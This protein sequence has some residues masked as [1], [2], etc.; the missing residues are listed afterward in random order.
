VRLSSAARQAQE[1]CPPP[2]RLSALLAAR[3]PGGDWQRSTEEALRKREAV[4][5][6]ETR[7]RE[8]HMEATLRAR[9]AELEAAAAAR[10]AARREQAAAEAAALQRSIEG[11]ERALCDA[12]ELE[13][14]RKARLLNPQAAPPPAP[15][16]DVAR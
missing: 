15:A 1:S 6:A 12:A 11:R 8:A 7:E 3:S 5:E 2:A 10:E 13:A 9:E 4:L 14:S 16:R